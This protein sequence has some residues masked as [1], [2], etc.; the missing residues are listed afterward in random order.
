VEHQ[1]NR[2]RG[3]DLTAEPHQRTAAGEVTCN[4][5]ASP[6]SVTHVRIRSTACPHRCGSPRGQKKAPRTPR[7]CPA[8]R[9]F[10]EKP[11]R[12][13]TRSRRF[14]GQVSGKSPGISPPKFRPSSIGPPKSHPPYRARRYA[15][16]RTRKGPRRTHASACADYR[17]GGDT[18]DYAQKSIASLIIADR[19]QR[20]G[21]RA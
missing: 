1:R 16:D 17:L 4:R 6:Q 11:T 12:R 10:D 13:K 8:S 15:D 19:C 18:A 9:L 3:R 14:R 2:V 7:A 21:A 20:V 5:P